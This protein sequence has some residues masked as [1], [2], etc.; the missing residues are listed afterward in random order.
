DPF[1]ATLDDLEQVPAVEGRTGI[2]AD[3]NRAQQLPARRIEGRQPVSRS[4]PHLPAVVRDAVYVVDTRKGPVLADDLGAGSAHDPSL[5]GRERG[6]EQQRRRG[7]R[8]GWGDPTARSA[9]PERLHLAR[10]GQRIERALRGALTRAE[11]ER[12]GRARPRFTVGEEGEHP[13]VL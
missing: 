9:A 8:H 4:E 1:D 2:R 10:F 12:E 13:R 5:V 6:R 11:R 7:S 3:L